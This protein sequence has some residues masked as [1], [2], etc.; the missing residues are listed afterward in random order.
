[1]KALCNNPRDPENAKCF[2]L[3]EPCCL[4]GASNT[5]FC[6]DENGIFQ[7]SDHIRCVGGMKDTIGKCVDERFEDKR[8]DDW[9]IG[10]SVEESFEDR[11]EWK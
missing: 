1:M 6:C 5:T 9:K 4:K 8:L 10:K 3:D 11:K 2:G 7:S